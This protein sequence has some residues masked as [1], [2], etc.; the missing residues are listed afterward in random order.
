MLSFSKL[1]DLFRRNGHSIVSVYVLHKK[2]SFLLLFCHTFHTFFLV[3]TRSL[4]LQ[5][6]ASLD[7]TTVFLD[8]TTSPITSSRETLVNDLLTPSTMT[9][10][11]PTQIFLCMSQYSRIYS[12]RLVAYIESML[13]YNTHIMYQN[14]WYTSRPHQSSL[15]ATYM[16]CLSIHDYYINQ[17]RVSDDIVHYTKTQQAIISQH[18]QLSL[19]RCQQTFPSLHTRL[20]HDLRRLHAELSSLSHRRHTLLSLYSRIRGQHS[21]YRHLPQTLRMLYET[22]CQSGMAFARFEMQLFCVSCFCFH[23]ENLLQRLDSEKSSS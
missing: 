7:L 13:H 8:P 12:Q 5:D 2:M 11:T 18:V 14:V 1:Y 17:Q 22:T 21:L 10:N 6:D 19:S 23:I 15:H 20:D 4:P 9:K 16:P 3:D